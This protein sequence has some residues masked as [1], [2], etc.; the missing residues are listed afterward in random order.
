MNRLAARL[1]KIERRSSPKAHLIFCGAYDPKNGVFPDDGRDEIARRI[2]DGEASTSD[3]F[4]RMVRIFVSPRPLLPDGT[5]H[6][7]AQP[8][9]VPTTPAGRRTFQSQ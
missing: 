8:L 7:L 6:D 5:G 4:Q 1:D 9:R 3:E 2:A